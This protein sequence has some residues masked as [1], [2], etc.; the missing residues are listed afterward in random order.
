VLDTTGGGWSRD[1]LTL[2]PGI[3]GDSGSG[4]LDASGEAIGVLSTLELA[5]IPAA[6]GVGDL[7]HELAY[8]HAQPG[9]AGV[10]LVPGTKPFIGS[11]LAA[12]L[13]L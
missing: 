13:G 8:L 9:F 5:P 1:V 7:A 6:N 4:F 3:P 2:T 12:L 11:L 10:R